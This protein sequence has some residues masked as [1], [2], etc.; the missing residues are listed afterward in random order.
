[1]S[2][3][4]NTGDTDGNITFSYNVSDFLG[5]K[6]CTLLINN[7]TNQTNSTITK[8]TKQ[9]ITVTNLAIGNYNWTTQCIDGFNNTGGTN[10][11]QFTVTRMTKYTGATTDLSTVGDISNITNF[12]IENT[13]AGKIN[14]SVSVNLSGGVDVDSYVTI[15]NNHV[16]VDSTN[17]PALNKAAR[18]SIFN[19]TLE[20]PEPLKDN[21]LCSACTEVSYLNG[22]FV[23]DATS[24]SVYSAGET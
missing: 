24:F 20:N 3:S 13:S 1:M 12:V 5:L 16:E 6:N 8:N 11:R 10:T 17:L 22:V 4:N 14:F 21:V 9:N 18:I 7:A 23:F 2:P 19:L 15:Q